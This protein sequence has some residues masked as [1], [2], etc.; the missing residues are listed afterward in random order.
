M[1]LGL[2]GFAPKNSTRDGNPGNPI[3]FLV[4]FGGSVAAITS[5]LVL[6]ILVL[7]TCRHRLPEYCLQNED[8]QPTEDDKKVAN[9]QLAE[10][11]IEASKNP[12]IEP[13]IPKKVTELLSINNENNSNDDNS[14]KKK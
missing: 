1:S 5:L 11:F 4:S 12:E 7:Y 8:D 2:F 3:V 6:A 14:F 9:T 10:F 13:L